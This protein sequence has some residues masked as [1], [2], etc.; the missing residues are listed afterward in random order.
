MAVAILQVHLK[1]GFFNPNGIEFPLALVGATALT[2]LAGA[3]KFSID[4]LIGRNKT[5]SV[6]APVERLRKAA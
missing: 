1:N 3:G 6:A 4:S 5:V 2:M